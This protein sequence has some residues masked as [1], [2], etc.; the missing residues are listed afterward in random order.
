M[1]IN[2]GYIFNKVSFLIKKEMKFFTSSDVQT[3]I[4]VDSFRRIAEDIEYPK[5]NYSSVVNSGVWTVPMPDDFIKVDKAKDIVFSDS[6]GIR[7]IT[8]KDQRNIGRDQ[9]LSATPGSPE[10]YFMEDQVTVGL[11]PPSTSGII[12]VPY[13]NVP[14]SLSSDS[15]TNQ[16]TERCYM[17][18]VYWTVAECMLKDSDEKYGVYMQKYDKEIQR[19]RA[20][21][22]DAF[23]EDKDFAPNTSYLT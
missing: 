19:L 4:G 21:Y 11:Y 13:V 7:K 23:E 20:D 3:I 10:N 15:D 12:I 6:T 17:A 5:S 18:S 1:T 2:R 9:V 16:L 22:G 14:T 8:P